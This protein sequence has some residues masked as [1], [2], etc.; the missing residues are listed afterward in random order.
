MERV[1][2]INRGTE[3]PPDHEGLAHQGL[4]YARAARGS[5]AA[6]RRELLFAHAWLRENVR[7]PG[8]A[9][10]LD[11]LLRHQDESGADARDAPRPLPL[12][13]QT[14]TA[15]ATV[16]Q[17]LGTAQGFQFLADVL[18]GAGYK[19][20][21]AATG[22][23][24]TAGSRFERCK[25][26]GV[27]ERYLVDATPHIV[28][29]A[30]TRYFGTVD[31]LAMSTAVSSAEQAEAD[32]VTGMLKGTVVEQLAVRLTSCCNGLIGRQANPE[33]VARYAERCVTLAHKVL[34]DLDVHATDQARERLRRVVSEWR[35][36]HPVPLQA[37]EPQ[38]ADRRVA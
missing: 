1:H 32:A 2:L 18:E 34:A 11:V 28:E 6:S 12:D 13:Q 10:V 22:A 3:L 24:Q 15:A 26:E 4:H 14:A 30:P 5:G 29:G 20:M 19:L 17:W 35:H 8:L 27:R 23:V 31:G 38:A 37:M 9:G 21:D 16:M 25:R 36:R 7:D 33:Q